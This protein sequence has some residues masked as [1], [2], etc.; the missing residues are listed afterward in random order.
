M[1]RKGSKK[2]PKLGDPSVHEGFYVWTERYF[3]WLRVRNYS[4]ATLG[5][6]RSGLGLFIEWAELRSLARPEDITRREME[7]YQRHLFHLQGRGGRPLGFRSQR[8]RISQ[9]SAFFRWL[10]KRGVLPG[11]P[12]ADL[13]LPRL[14]NRLVK[15]VLTQSEAEA[16]LAL[17]DT[18]SAVGLRD[19]AM[20]ELFYSTGIRRTELA[21][22]SVG[23]LDAEGRTLRVRRGKGK[24]ERY[25]PVGER[26]VFWLET[27]LTKVRPELARGAD[28]DA[29]FLSAD[30][31]PLNPDWLG[32]RVRGYVKESGIA[33]MGGCHLFRH[34]M[35]TL[36]L[37][38]GADV[39]FIQEILGH[40]SLESTQIYTRVSLRKLRAVHEETHPAAKLDRPLAKALQAK[41]ERPAGYPRSTAVQNTTP[42]HVAE[43]TG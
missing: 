25:V 31:T 2:R 40:E 6:A 8:V 24:K 30:G 42:A 11:N 5:N 38:G 33:K 13:E 7:R 28:T 29:L 4:P 10:V 12:A 36:M 16:V 18:T 23:D 15:D 26:A 43:G 41:Y 34:T 37:E 9:V 21:L 35:A 19:R 20:L 14:P 17:P 39:R 22:L 32:Q 27:Y 1:P 3:E